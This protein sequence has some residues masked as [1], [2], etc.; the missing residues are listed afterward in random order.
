MIERFRTLW[1]P[2]WLL[3]GLTSIILLVALILSL[4]LYLPYWIA[5]RDATEPTGREISANLIAIPEDDSLEWEG[6]PDDRQLLVVNW[7]SEDE[8]FHEGDEGDPLTPG[9]VFRTNKDVWVTVVPQLQ[10]VCRKI[11]PECSGSGLDIRLKQLLG[12]PLLDHIRLKQ[13]LGLPPYDHFLEKTQFV[14]FLVSPS[15]LFRPCPDPAITDSVCNLKSPMNVEGDRRTHKEWFDNQ[16][17]GSYRFPRGYPWTQLG[18]TYDWGN[19][20]SEF[21]LSEFVIEKG[22]TVEV[23]SVKI[24]DSYLR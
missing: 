15:D 21:G 10:T 17:K 7:S 5:I 22:A 9:D 6:E 14:V 1:L 2:I 16:K 18:Y 8:S 23:Q 20:R 19:P 4:L 12:L 11:R 13:L 24:T 3:L